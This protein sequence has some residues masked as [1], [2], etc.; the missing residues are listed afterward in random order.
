MPENDSVMK[1]KLKS[2]LPSEM[3]GGV[4]ALERKRKKWRRET[5]KHLRRMDR[6]DKKLHQRL[7]E[8]FRRFEAGFMKQFD[9]YDEHTAQT[10]EKLDQEMT[11][12]LDLFLIKI[13]KH[14]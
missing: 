6:N 11:A 5:K 12:K 4:D 7:E 10:Y 2:D 9:R 1:E 8:S 13:R 3:D 14:A